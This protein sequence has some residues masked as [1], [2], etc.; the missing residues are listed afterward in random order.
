MKFGRSTQENR[1]GSVQYCMGK[2]KEEKER[3]LRD[4]SFIV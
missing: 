2:K 3:S 4:P 1:A